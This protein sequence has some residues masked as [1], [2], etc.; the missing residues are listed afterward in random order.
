MVICWMRRYSA[1]AILREGVG[2]GWKFRMSTHSG[3]ISNSALLVY[4]EESVLIQL[5]NPVRLSVLDNFRI[6]WRV[7]MN[8]KLITSVVLMAGVLIFLG[9]KPSD[10]L[11]QGSN[12]WEKFSRSF[13]GIFNG[14]ASKRI[15]TEMAANTSADLQAIC[16]SGPA[17]ANDDESSSI[18][19]EINHERCETLRNSSVIVVSPEGIKQR[20]EDQTKNLE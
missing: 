4:A 16:N 20:L 3:K 14:E 1:N 8:F 7:T 13:L 2:Q 12:E 6:N 17:T 15:A 18:A 11:E 9:I 19:R 5:R 10:L